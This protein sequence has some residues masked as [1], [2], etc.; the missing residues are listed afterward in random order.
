MVLEVMKQI[1]KALFLI[2]LTA[3]FSCEEQGLFVNCSDCKTDQPVDTSIEI[4]LDQN[5]YAI[6]TVINIYEGNLE[7]NILYS[8]F[9]TSSKSTTYTVIVN[10]KYTLTASYF[11]DNKQYI[12]VDSATPRVKY[13]KDDCD[14]PCYFVYDKK[15]NLSLK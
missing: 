1:L 9:S 8:T 14:D 5:N 15:V 11:I 2:I 12:A 7:D 6:P 4:K 3:L 10:K 13:T